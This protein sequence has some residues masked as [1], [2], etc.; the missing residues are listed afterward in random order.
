[1]IQRYN[2][3]PASIIAK[4]LNKCVA[5]INRYIN[6]WNEF[7]IT[8]IADHRGGNI[9]SSLTGEM[10]EDIRKIVTNKSLP[11]LWL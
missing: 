4:N 3:V 5:T 10:V 2:G 8:L 9:P 1:M 6:R 7:G 11:T